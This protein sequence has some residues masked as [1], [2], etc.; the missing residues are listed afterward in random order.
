[1]APNEVC[2]FDDV[3]DQ[4][5]RGMKEDDAD[6]CVLRRISRNQTLIYDE[7]GPEGIESCPDVKA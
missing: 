6:R 1:M 5:R 3:V 7:H 2:W 4:K